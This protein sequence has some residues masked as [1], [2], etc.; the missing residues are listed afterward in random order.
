MR[1]LWWAFKAG[2]VPE[3]DP[4]SEL[5][6][7]DREY[8]KTICSADYRPVHF[9]SANVPRLALFKDL[10]EKGYSSEQSAVLVGMTINRVGL[11]DNTDRQPSGPVRSR[12]KTG[13]VSKMELPIEH[14]EFVRAYKSGL[15]RLWVNPLK[16]KEVVGSSIYEP[17][18][19]DLR[20]P[21][22]LNKRTTLLS[23]LV[24]PCLIGAVV[25]PFLWIWWSF[26][27]SIAGALVCIHLTSRYQREAVRQLALADE[28]AY[29]FL[30]LQGVILLDEL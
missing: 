30:R 21:R 9:G 27:L 17:F 23:L 1:K 24:I 5:S 4:L 18:F 3:K 25:I 6:E 13:G 11:P 19:Q 2:H 28:K 20:Y 22:I 12:Q 8:T 10:L 29:T 15:V 26:F 7:D 14:H 16:V